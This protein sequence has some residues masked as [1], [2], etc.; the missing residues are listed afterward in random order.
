MNDTLA[1][2]TGSFDPFTLGH[3][4]LVAR[5]AAMFSRVCVAVLVN[6]DKTYM[7]SVEERVALIRKAVAEYPTVS[8]VA[9]DG[10]TTD[11]ARR[12]GA[13]CLV[14]GIR[15]EADAAYE[16]AM[17]AYNMQ[18]GGVDTICLFC[19]DMAQV[20]SGAVRE[21]L[22]EGLSLEGWMPDSIIAETLAYYRTK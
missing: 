7:F 16:A 15:N 22:A 21:R 17:A 6:P 10:M 13:T 2:V 12:L 11:L 18:H 20:S 14:R 3:L 4:S 1:M 9:F 19:D 5:A 8:V